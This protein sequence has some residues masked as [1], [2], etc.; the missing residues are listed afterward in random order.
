TLHDGRFLLFHGALHPT[1]DS[2]LHLSTGTRV[3][4]T[5]DALDDGPWGVRLAFFGHTHRALVH[6]RLDAGEHRTYRNFALRLAPGARYL[7]TPGSVG[8]PRD[9]DARASFLIYDDEQ[10]LVRF[11]RVP[12]DRAA[13]LAKAS[14]AGLLRA[15]ED[16]DARSGALTRAASGL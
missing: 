12:F 3:E 4:R 15:R 1:P 16:D 14:R 10:R 6:E 13:C 2:D 9:G 11:L 5:F 8:Q 7:V